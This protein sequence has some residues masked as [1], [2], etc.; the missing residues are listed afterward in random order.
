MSARRFI[1][2]VGY[3]VLE[4]MGLILAIL[5]KV[6]LYSLAIAASAYIVVHAF[7]FLA[8][9]FHPELVFLK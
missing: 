7:L 3:R 8:S 5:A 6:G 1:N 9:M 4:S 2:D